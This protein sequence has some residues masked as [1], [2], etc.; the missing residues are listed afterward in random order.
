MPQARS[1]FEAEVCASDAPDDMPSQR[2]QI[3]LVGWVGSINPA[4]YP[5]RSR[6][7]VFMEPTQTLRSRGIFVE[8]HRVRRQPNPSVPAAFIDGILRRG[9]GRVGESTHRHIHGFF[10]AFFRVEDR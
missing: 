9:K 7:R 10:M 6:W 2:N 8:P 1:V 4:L 5:V 3:H